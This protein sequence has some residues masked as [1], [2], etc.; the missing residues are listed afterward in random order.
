MTDDRYSHPLIQLTRANTV[1]RHTEQC[2]DVEGEATQWTPTVAG[3]S[4]VIVV[5]RF[6]ILQ[7][8]GKGLILGAESVLDNVKGTKGLYGVEEIEEGKGHVIYV[9]D[10]RVI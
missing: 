5:P 2:Q 4:A 6:G 8:N 3:M 7:S 9:L 10:S 1:G